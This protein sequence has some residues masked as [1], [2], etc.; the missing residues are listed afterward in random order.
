MVVYWGNEGSEIKR[1][2]QYW[3]NSGW[4]VLGCWSLM[5]GLQHSTFIHKSGP[6]TP[7]ARFRL[8]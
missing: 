2:P 5:S 3:S 1:P 6:R 7:A 4:V 8:C